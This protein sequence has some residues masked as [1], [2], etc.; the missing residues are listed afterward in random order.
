MFVLCAGL[1]L[2]GRL[3]IEVMPRRVVL[4]F[5]WQVPASLNCIN[6]HWVN[7]TEYGFSLIRIF[8]Y[9]DRICD[10]VFI[11]ESKIQRKPVSWLILFFGVTSKKYIPCIKNLEHQDQFHIY[12]YVMSNILTVN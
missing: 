4:D 8:S 10:F 3:W 11:R 12:V 7:I 9:K 6:Y 2:S 1:R 5:E